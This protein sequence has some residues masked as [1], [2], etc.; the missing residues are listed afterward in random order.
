[1]M[2]MEAVIE[3]IKVPEVLIDP[4]PV[5]SV[6]QELLV[7]LSESTEPILPA[8]SSGLDHSLE[9]SC[10]PSSGD[11]PSAPPMVSAEPPLSPSE[12]RDDIGI[13][14]PIFELPPS[15]VGEG[16]TPDSL[17][18]RAT[19]VGISI[20][21]PVESPR[22]SAPM[23]WEQI[24][25]SNIRIEDA[26]PSIAPPAQSDEAPLFGAES[27]PASPSMLQSEPASDQLASLT[28][29]QELPEPGQSSEVDSA[30]SSAVVSEPEEPTLSFVA[31]PEPVVALQASSE[32]TPEP[33][34]P[35]ALSYA[36]DSS[37]SPTVLSEP[38]VPTLSF[39][40]QS[41]SVEAP[42]ASSVFAPEPTMPSALS[43]AVDSPV[44]PEPEAPTPSSTPRAH[45]KIG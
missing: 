38:E 15:V 26:A 3:S 35:S 10:L 14:Q 31:Q 2:A 6:P 1:M 43:Y 44:V 22:L 23:P 42:L 39:I 8:D 21:S 20:P 16:P 7:P 13:G 12:H 9:M 45:T 18:E 34:V 19:E 27:F 29:S 36:V 25:H 24:E 5:S 32:F 33:T 28:F 4:A 41:E 17:E 40:A 11:A 37:A 30:V